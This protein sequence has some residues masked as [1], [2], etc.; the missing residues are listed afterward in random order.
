MNGYT[1]HSLGAVTKV[2]RKVTKHPASAPLPIK[3][4]SCLPHN[5][6]QSTCSVISVICSLIRS[7]N[8][9]IRKQSQTLKILFYE[10]LLCNLYNW[11][12]LA[13]RAM[14]THMLNKYNYVYFLLTIC[15]SADL[16]VCLV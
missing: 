6:R 2:L 15:E 16:H 5:C 4:T 7:V 1:E 8:N 11:I 12:C 10:Y 13:V 3:L 14:L 9:G